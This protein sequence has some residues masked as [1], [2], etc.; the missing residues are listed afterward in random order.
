MLLAERRSQKERNKRAA[1]R[2]REGCG[3]EKWDRSWMGSGQTEHPTNIFFSEGDNVLKIFFFFFS[4]S[5]WE[6]PILLMTKQSSLDLMSSHCIARPSLAYE[7]Y[8]VVRGSVT[9]Q[10]SPGNSQD[11]ESKWTVEWR[12]FCQLLFSRSR[13]NCQAQSWWSF[14][15]FNC[16]KFRTRNLRHGPFKF[17]MLQR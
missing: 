10:L 7:V 5:G 1:E 3:S 17:A 16:E 4:E 12:L 15:R 13:T 8:S 9:L 11:L 6:K 2:T 14:T